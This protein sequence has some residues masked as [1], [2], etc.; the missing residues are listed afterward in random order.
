MYTCSFKLLRFVLAATG[1][2]V[3]DQS[4]R[5]LKITWSGDSSQYY[6]V[7]EASHG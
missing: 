7:R 1:V 2:Q 5:T 3:V 4:A 6:E